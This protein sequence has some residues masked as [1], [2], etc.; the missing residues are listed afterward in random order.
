L[1]PTLLLVTATHRKLNGATVRAMRELLGVKHGHFA[2]D[3]EVSTGYL[4]NI[5]AGRKQP[6]PAV[7]RR[8]AARLGVPLDAITYPVPGDDV[9]LEASA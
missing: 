7:A 6:D 3:T 9:A 1:F 4:S 8:F 5:E 2:R